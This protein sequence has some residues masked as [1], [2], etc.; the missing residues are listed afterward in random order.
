VQILDTTLRDGSYVINFQFT[1]EDTFLIASALDQIGI[2]L[3]EVG[4]GLG[5][6]ATSNSKMKAACPDEEYFEATQRAVTNGK[7]GMF[8][9]PGIGRLEDIEKAAKYGMDF[10][11][12][13]VDV[14]D[15]E[16]AAHFIDRAKSLGLHVSSNLMKSYALPPN[17]VA[18]KVLVAEKIGAD[19]VCIVD[20]AGGMFPEDI[21]NYFREIRNIS[22][23]PLGF[24]GHNNLG[25]A[26]ANTLKAAELGAE[27][28]DTSL[29]GMGRSAGNAVTEIILLGL[30]RKGI[31][32][33]INVN[34]LLD[35]AEKTIDPLLKNHPQVDSIGIISGFAQ[36]HSSFL[37]VVLEYAERF[38]IDPRD[39]I[40][41][42]AKKDQIHAPNNLVEK[43]A[44][45]L[46]AEKVER[47]YPQ[48]ESWR[49]G[50]ISQKG[51]TSESLYKSVEI[52]AQQA[53]VTAQKFNLNTVFN[54]VQTLRPKC[55]CTIYPSLYEGQQFVVASGEVDNS[56]DALDLAE[57][58]DGKFDYLLL[59]VDHK[60]PQSKQFVTE[61]KKILHKTSVLIY[62]DLEIWTKSIKLFLNQLIGSD[63][64]GQ[65]G[66]VIGKNPLSE[67]L[68]KDLNEF[69]FSFSTAADFNNCKDMSGYRAVIV[70]EEIQA[71]DISQLAPDVIL[72][73]AFIRSFNAEI[74]QLLNKNEILIYRPEMYA[75][76]HAEIQSNVFF[77]QLINERQGVGE[78]EGVKIASGGVIV[79]RGAVIVDSIKNPT[80]IYGITNG[81]G[82]L[83]LPQQ[84]SHDETKAR[85]QVGQYIKLKILQ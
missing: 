85:E 14:T 42:V 7:W 79:P 8:F 16:H 77:F 45:E 19:L 13:G 3:I 31:D 61:I 81:E 20:S 40:V 11:R 58:V 59:D 68:L 57:A 67:R 38:R 64:Q 60:F 10:I 74:I 39:L 83:L 17:E 62:S 73:D 75:A 49:G 65:K 80:K 52:L 4:H 35:I 26:I 23:I 37:G 82:S 84:L 32:L 72:I 33:G 1:A 9:I 12:I 18:E 55:G 51:I 22:N 56:K 29:R 2:P 44:K 76:I 47:K 53:K 70:T 66:V 6:N 25:L 5:L 54:L 27:I 71:L 30:Q 46:A 21:E 78:I 28:I 63:L 43:L 34:K 24:H 69:G 36:F 15:I 50:N 48:L 41:K